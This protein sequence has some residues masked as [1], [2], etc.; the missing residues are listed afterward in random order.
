MPVISD[1]C[2]IVITMYYDDHSPPHF[3]AS[4]GENC[5]IIS[6]NECRVVKGML[7]SKPLKLVLAWTVIHQSELLLNW[8]LA[9]GHKKLNRIDPLR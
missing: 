3:H 5:A 8:E 1:F 4:Y 6:I 2:G 7:P 9:R